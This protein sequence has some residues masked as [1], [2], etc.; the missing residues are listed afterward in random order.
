MSSRNMRLLPWAALRSGSEHER[1]QKGGHC[2]H[3]NKRGQRCLDT[4]PAQK[5]SEIFGHYIWT[6]I[7][8]VPDIWILCAYR[9]ESPRFWDTLTKSPIHKI[10]NVHI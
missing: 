5:E 10:E 7:Q 1:S 2:L 4:I 6:P 3:T 9:D 8:E